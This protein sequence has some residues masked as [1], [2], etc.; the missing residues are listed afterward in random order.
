M[1]FFSFFILWKSS[2]YYTIISYVHKFINKNIFSREGLKPLPSTP[3][4]V[5]PHYPW[6]SVVFLVCMFLHLF[7]LLTSHIKIH[8]LD[9]FILRH[10]HLKH[11]IIYL[12]YVHIITF[13]TFSF[14]LCNT[15][16]QSSKHSTHLNYT[17]LHNI[18]NKIMSLI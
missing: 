6:S 18:Q 11:V 2:S 16:F 14:K 8:F 7:F 10:S 3:R 5:G 4:R 9:T 13:T 17:I 15:I 12:N 1:S